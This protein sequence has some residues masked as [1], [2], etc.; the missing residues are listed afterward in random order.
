MVGDPSSA[1]L[2]VRFGNVGGQITCR[3][4][5]EAGCVTIHLPITVSVKPLPNAIIS[6]GGTVCPGSPMNLF[7]DFT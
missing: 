3:E 5:N 6:G 2:S 7:V 1:T 4:T